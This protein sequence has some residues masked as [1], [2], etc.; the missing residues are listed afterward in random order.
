MRKK[1]KNG[2]TEDLLSSPTRSSTERGHHGFQ[3][4]KLPSQS[5]WLNEATS[6]AERQS[7]KQ[8]VLGGSGRSLGRISTICS[9]DGGGRF[10]WAD[11]G[12]KC[13]GCVFSSLDGG[14]RWWKGLWL[15]KEGHTY[16]RKQWIPWNR[17]NSIRGEGNQKVYFSGKKFPY[18]ILILF[19]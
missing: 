4:F 7:F 14:G 16:V 1:M 5:P 18:A 6:L 9:L 19:P 13:S 12:K 11:G 17:L 15:R 8:A 2:S 10:S 3:V